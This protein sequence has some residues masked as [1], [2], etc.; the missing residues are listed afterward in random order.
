MLI[1]KICICIE[2][3][4]NRKSENIWKYFLIHF[5]SVS[6]GFIWIICPWADLLPQ[7]LLKLRNRFHDNQISCRYIAWIKRRKIQSLLASV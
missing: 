3:I 1:F 5:F 2:K 7:G 4:Q 6:K